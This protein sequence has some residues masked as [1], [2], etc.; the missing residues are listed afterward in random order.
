MFFQFL[1]LHNY[2]R[3]ENLDITFHDKLSVIVGKN[4][5][6]K[7]TVLD[8]LAISAG[9]MLNEF[10][11]IKNVSI[12]K[13]HDAHEKY[14]DM[15]SVVDVQPQYPVEIDASG[16][17]SGTE[18]KWRRSLNAANGKTTIADAKEMTAISKIY[19]EKLMHGDTSLVLPLI[20]YYGTGRMWDLHREKKS[21]TLR[22]NT[23]TNGYI[24]SLDSTASVKL[25]MKWFH[26]MARKDAETSVKSMEYAA[27][28]GAMEQCLASIT[29]TP[30][31]KVQYNLDT[32]ELDVIY[33]E[34]DE[35]RV[36]IPLSQLS[37]GYRCALSLIA[38]IA[39][40]MATLNPSLSDQVL[41]QTEGVVLVDEIDLH[42][43]PEWQQRI[44][45]D[46][47]NI[48]PNVQF[49]VTTHAP[50]VINSVTNEN[51][52]ILEDGASKELYQE[53]ENRV[54]G[55][56]VNNILSSVMGTTERPQEVLEKFQKFYRLLDDGK[57]DAAE[58]LLQ[59]L[60]NEIG[61]SDPEIASCHVSLDLEKL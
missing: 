37:D 55:R 17:V 56:D 45:R 29:K 39:Y 32:L 28:C 8:A 40:R 38:D 60:E 48:F 16:I 43:H 14:Y 25:M 51:L 44:L 3:F 10:D 34:K 27:V 53:S 11:G 19:R 6:G 41:I 42:L 49:I 26:K 31:V 36:R 7:T 20:A 13:M 58:A 23:R 4:G 1:H 50:A 46:L 52:I 5:A 57:F 30:D 47:Q 2:R 33:R 59:D 12:N 24:D 18:I 21:D 54:Y 61:E 9:T 22:K 15:G 35:S